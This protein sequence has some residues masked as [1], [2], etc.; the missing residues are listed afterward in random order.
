MTTGHATTTAT[1]VMTIRRA[2]SLAGRDITREQVSF[3]GLGSIG[4]S[5]LRLMLSALPHPQQLSFCDIF[6]KRGQLEALLA[7]VRSGFHF[8][9]PAAILESRKER[10]RK[11]TNRA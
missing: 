8:H 11:S 2:L 9:G 1:V 3:L 10:R 6:S 7:E 5:T 4:T